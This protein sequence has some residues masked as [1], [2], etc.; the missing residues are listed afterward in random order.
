MRKTYLRFFVASCVLCLSP[1]AASAQEAPRPA[2]IQQRAQAQQ[3]ERAQQSNQAQRDQDRQRNPNQAQVGEQVR[4]AQGQQGQHADKSVEHFLIK[5]MMLGNKAE[6]E[7]GQIAVQKAEHEDVKQFA[8]KLVQDH[9]QMNQELE[10]LQA[11]GQSGARSAQP[12]QADPTRSGQLQPGQ[13]TSDRLGQAQSEQAVQPGQDRVS[14]PLPGQTQLGQAG[15]NQPGQSRPA[16]DTAGRGEVGQ[17]R[18][19]QSGL[20]QQGQSQGQEIPQQLTQLTEQT[21][22]NTLQMARRM[23][24]EAEQGKEFDMTFV[25]MQIVKHS[26]MVAELDSMR[27]VGS[28]QFQQLVSKAHATTQQH[29]DMAKNL[30]KQLSGDD[31]ASRSDATQRSGQA[32]P[33]PSQNRSGGAPNPSGSQGNN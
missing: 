16:Q 7:L 29:L 4:S 30:S 17:D 13:S 10:Q 21:A 33:N 27:N 2:Q 23:L 3:D 31:Q 14:Q 15:Q 25:G 26:H 28:P 8:Q 1:L 32:Q 20:A 18:L 5:K 11:G 12:G 22:Q 19:R 6:I 24:E 9:Q